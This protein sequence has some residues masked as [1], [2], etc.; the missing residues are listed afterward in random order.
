MRNLASYRNSAGQIW[1]NI[2]SSTLVLEDFVNIDNNIFLRYNTFFTLFK[3]CLPR[4]YWR[5]LELNSEAMCK[6]TIIAH[7]CRRRLFF[8]D[9][10]IDHILCSHFLEHVFPDEMESILRDFYRVLKPGGTLH[11]VVPDLRAQA[12]RYISRSEDSIAGDDF[13]KET[14]LSRHSRGS[15][16]YRLLELIGAFGLQ[17]RWMYDLS[18]ITNKLLSA[19]FEITQ[20][21]ETPSKHFRFGDGSVH[22]LGFKP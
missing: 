3:W 9:D 14:V 16:K 15:T 18:S 12:V 2:A 19:G 5:S 8:P 20:R 10:S 17:H 4:R 1:L 6:A 7:D 22:A 11:I 21:I 13:I